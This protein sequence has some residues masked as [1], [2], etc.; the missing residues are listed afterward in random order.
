MNAIDPARWSTERGANSVFIELSSK[1]AEMVPPGSAIVDDVW[2]VLPWMRSTRN[3]SRRNAYFDAIKHPELRTLCKLWVLHGRLTNAAN[4]LA[5]VEFR[6]AAMAALAHVLGARPLLALKT[7]DFLAAERWLRDSYASAYR[8]AGYLQQASQWLSTSFNMRLAYRNRLRNPI[9]YGRYGTDAERAKKLIPTDIL[10]DLL[11]AR[12]RE[13]LIAKDKFFLSVLMVSVGTG[14]RVG[15][16][17]LLPCNCLIKMKG[18]LHLLH[19]PEKAGKPVPR[20]IHPLL[21]DVIEDAVGEILRATSSAREIAKRMRNDPPLDWSGII[22]D[23]AALSYF[24]A[25]WAHGWT[26][27]PAHQMINPT[28][29]W[30][31]KGKRFIDA[32]GTLEAVGGNQSEASRRLGISRL[33]FSDLLA[34]QR[35][36]RNGKLPPVRNSKSRG[37]ARESWNTDQRVISIEKFQRYCGV[38]VKLDRRMRIQSILDEARRLQLQGHSFP[39]PV[40]DPTIEQRF[41]RPLAPLLRNQDGTAIL[42]RDEALLIIQKYALSEERRTIEADFSSLT[43]K[44][45]ARWLSGEARS[46]GTG[47]HEDS[48]FARLG[49]TDPRTGKVA[50]FTIHDVRHWLN[51]IYQNGGLTEDQIALIFNRKYKAQNASYDQTSSKIRSERLKQAVRDKVIVGQ[52]TDSYSRLAE[53][54]RDDAEDY[55]GAVLRMVNPMPHGICTLGWATTPCP[56]HL[57]CFSCRDERPCEHLIVDPADKATKA[58]LERMQRESD[59]VIAAI[60]SQGV[61][62]SPTADHFKR[63]RHN[64]GVTLDEIRK[65]NGED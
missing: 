23:N 61:Q 54:S 47:N 46:H 14:F 57:S 45:I 35:A 55:L 3:S 59:L 24:T 1:L 63:I 60:H 52:V 58:E 29:A 34:T 42:H 4:S 44:S 9:V 11:N 32:I 10:R 19:Y 25:R 56:H 62:S 41:R 8:R 18:G 22:R 48:V 40:A 5:A 33:T 7:D 65:I 6:I 43:E 36:A 13:G 17:A 27:D 38:H 20:P 2:N 51:T 16:L 50:K 49:I 26:V 30:Y 15:E 28:G 31:T 21:A 12:H 39:A 37:K 64:V 53:F